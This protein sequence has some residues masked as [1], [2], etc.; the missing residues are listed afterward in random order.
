MEEMVA[1][2]R[3]TNALREP[4]RQIKGTVDDIFKSIEGP[5]LTSLYSRIIFLLEFIIIS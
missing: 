4:I 1:L 3:E 2:L 5:S